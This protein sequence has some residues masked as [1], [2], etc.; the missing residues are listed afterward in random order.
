MDFTDWDSKGMKGGGLAHMLGFSNGG[1]LSQSQLV[2]M[3]MDEGMSYE[4]AVQAASASQ[5]LPWDILSKAKGGRVPM[6]YG[7]D[8]G[9]AFEY[10]GS[11][12]DWRDNH[13]HM[14]PLMEYIGTKLPKENAF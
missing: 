10:G 2:Q 7:G 4:D 14:M 3:Y 12:A 11:W 5:G 9:F 8:P 6:M 1:P 13:Q